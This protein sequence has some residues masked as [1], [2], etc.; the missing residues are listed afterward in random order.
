MYTLS[1]TPINQLYTGAYIININ[2]MKY[3]IGEKG[4]TFCVTTDIYIVS[5][6]IVV[7]DVS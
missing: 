6:I 7:S 1:P 3:I 4:K 2:N 5:I